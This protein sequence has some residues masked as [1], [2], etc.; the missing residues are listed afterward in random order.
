[1]LNGK[2]LDFL[3]WTSLSG[4][5]FTNDLIK[6]FYLLQLPFF[7][8]GWSVGTTLKKKISKTYNSVTDNQ[9][10]LQLGK[11]RTIHSPSWRV[12]SQWILPLK[13]SGIQLNSICYGE[14][15]LEAKLCCVG[16]RCYVF[17]TLRK[18]FKHYCYKSQ[19]F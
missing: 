16:F 14:T 18:A 19:D 5:S 2:T 12:F 17:F 4:Q 3:G 8:F 6:L 9:T 10:A 15:F 13:P 11:T 1:M 7:F